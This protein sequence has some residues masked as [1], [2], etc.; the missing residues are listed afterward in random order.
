MVTDARTFLSRP[1][2]MEEVFGPSTPVVECASPAEMLAVARQAEGQLTATL[3]ATPE[4]LAMHGDLLDQLAHKV[5]RLVFK[6]FPT[7]VE[8][9]HAMTHGG[10]YPA[11]SDGRSTSVG[12]RAIE[13]FL[14]PVSRQNFP[15]GALPPELRE[16]NP[17]GLTRLVD[18][19]FQCGPEKNADLFENRRSGAR[20]SEAGPAKLAP[21]RRFVPAIGASGPAQATARAAGW[22]PGRNAEGPRRYL[23]QHC[24]N[25]LPLPQG[26]GSLRPTLGP[27]RMGL[28]FSSCCAASLT[29]SLA[30]FLTGGAPVPVP[31]ALLS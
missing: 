3:H 10:P 14:R 30:L 18:G 19:T 24:L 5:G 9:A 12:T 26:Q 28:A 22:F 8:V 21:L 23:P 7:G 31:K 1:D 4:E 16:A 20:S 25:F 29:T 6:G 15:D 13:R 2:L 17:L 27:V 11:T